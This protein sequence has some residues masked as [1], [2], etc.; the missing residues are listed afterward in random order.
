[1][2][3][4]ILCLA[5]AAI[6]G[7]AVELPELSVPHCSIGHGAIDKYYENTA[8]GFELPLEETQTQVCW[9]ASGIAISTNNS[10]DD[11]W[12]TCTSCG[13]SNFAHGDVAEVFLAPVSKPDLAPTWYYELDVGAVTG[14]FW[15]GITHNALGNDTLYSSAFPCSAK[16]P[17]DGFSG[18]PMNCSNTLPIVEVHTGV[19]WWARE[20]LVPWTL[21]RAEFV[22]SSKHPSPW[23]HWRANFYRY[24]YPFKLANGSYNRSKP[25]LSAWSPT[26]S[27]SFHVPPQFG[28]LKFLTLDTLV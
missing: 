19:R 18:C 5:L 27:G 22:P 4:S 1:M 12:Q 10:E 25:E 13:C 20:M 3:R 9:N 11:I 6:T 8:S 21:F 17:P 14:A 16:A 7:A 28:K 2:V 15:G 24:A 23:Q 26:H